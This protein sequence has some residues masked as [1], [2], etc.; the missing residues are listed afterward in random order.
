MRRSAVGILMPLAG[1]RTTPTHSAQRNPGLEMLDGQPQSFR[2][3]DEQEQS[4]M[5]RSAPSV[6]PATTRNLRVQAGHWLR[7]LRESRGLSQREMANKV[8][9]INYTSISQFEHGRGR[10]SPDDYRA[11]CDA[12]GVD[13]RDFVMRLMSYYDPVTYGILFGRTHAISES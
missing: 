13:C 3:S 6:S 5:P 4:S 10:I 1:W 9:L 2:S 7:H 11:W 12:L 8:G